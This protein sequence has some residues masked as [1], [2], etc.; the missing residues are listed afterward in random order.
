MS[1]YFNMETFSTIESYTQFGHTFQAIDAHP[2]VR[3]EVLLKQRFSRQ[4]HGVDATPIAS[5]SSPQAYN[6][7]ELQ[8]AIKSVSAS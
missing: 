4:R 8:N 7:H 2:L 6:S 5:P 3:Y 1:T